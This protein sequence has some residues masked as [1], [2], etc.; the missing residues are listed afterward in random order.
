MAG[1]QAG[2]RNGGDQLR[3][4]FAMGETL[5]KRAAIVIL[6]L[7]RVDSVAAFGRSGSLK[8]DRPGFDPALK[9]GMLTLQ[10]GH[11]WRTD[12]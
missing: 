4:F 3:E 11:C 2:F 1:R 10:A 9:F 6:K 12:A 5:A 7:F 8:V